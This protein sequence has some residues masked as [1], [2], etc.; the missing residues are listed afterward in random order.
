M[1]SY[2]LYQAFEDILQVQSLFPTVVFF[3]F[4]GGR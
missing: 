1:T 3:C 2:F 4:T